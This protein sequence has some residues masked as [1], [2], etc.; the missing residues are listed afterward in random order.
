MGVGDAF[1]FLKSFSTT[2]DEYIEN[3]ERL[4]NCVFV[5][6]VWSANVEAISLVFSIVFIQRCVLSASASTDC[7]HV[8]DQC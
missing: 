5:D 2:L 6:H 4:L 8:L 7:G 3:F 1:V